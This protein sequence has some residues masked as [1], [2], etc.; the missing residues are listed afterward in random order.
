MKVNK[1]TFFAAVFLL[2]MTCPGQIKIA[3]CVIYLPPGNPRSVTRAAQELQKHIELATGNKLEIISEART[4]MIALG[5]S[6]EARKA[7]VDA[8]TMKYETHIMRTTGGNLYIAGRDI[9]GD[10]RAE[11][12]GYSYGTL[13]GVYAFMNQVM[14]I[15]F[16]M[17]TDKGTYVPKLG[18]DWKIPAVDKTY[19][20]QFEYRGFPYVPRD[21]GA[22]LEWKIRN[23]SDGRGDAGSAIPNH[24]HSWSNIYPSPGS[25]YSQAN[26]DRTAAFKEHPEFFYADNSGNRIYP[27]F[28]FALCISNPE[29]W[30]DAAER[31][32][33]LRAWYRKFYK[34]DFKFEMISLSPND[35]TNCRCEECKKRYVTITEK[36]VGAWKSKP[37]SMFCNTDLMLDY[38]RGVT[39][40]LAAKFQYLETGGLIYDHY[41][42][43]WKINR[44]K[45]PPQFGAMMAPLHLSY[46]PGRLYSKINDSW[47]KWLNDWDGMFERKYYYGLDFW[48]VQSAGAPWPVFAKMRNDTYPVLAKKGF[49][50][51]YLYGMDMLGVTAAHN[52]LQMQQAW[53]PMLDAEKA[54]DDF[55]TKAYGGGGKYVKE[56]YLL[57]EKNLTEFMTALKGKMGYYMTPELM[58]DVYAKDWKQF[59]SLM[60]KAVNAPKDENQAWRLDHFVRNMRL[61]NYHLEKMGMIPEDK[62]AKLYLSDA[63]YLSWTPLRTQG[64]DWQTLGGKWAFFLPQPKRNGF[65]QSAQVPI[66]EVRAATFKAPTGDAWFY[67]TADFLV[68]AVSDRVTFRIE[69]KAS[70]NPVTQ[71]PYLDGIPYFSVFTP[72]GE[73]YYSGIAARNKV[74]FPAKKGI[75]YFMW[76]YPQSDTTYGHTWR[77]VKANSPYAVGTRIHPAGLQ[78][79]TPAGS[80]LYFFVPAGLKKFDLIALAWGGFD[81]LDPTGKVIVSN[82]RIGGYKVIPVRRADGYLEQGVYELRVTSNL[83]GRIRFSSELPGFFVIDP[84]HALQ[85]TLDEKKL[86]ERQKKN[87]F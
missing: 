70:I 87:R 59:S 58:K 7:G 4:P 61:F 28:N 74:S 44:K 10:R 31:Y 49:N 86:L 85:V 25:L 53:N 8:S 5:S 60:E 6:P 55:C 33:K 27:K 79:H 38:Y 68:Q 35:G 23:F 20:P 9:P 36:E 48:F 50:G 83:W 29:V 66:K 40:Q 45:M 75:T 57:A 3:D 51:T 69:Q 71:K 24:G 21:R 77:I 56:I 32:I 84:A 19:T 82:K 22:C 30:K 34:L 73:L 17:P 78:I 47:H 18:K 80:R 14:G 37:Q 1:T 11:K 16:L 13:Y 39:E 46:G 64:K 62:T 41:M 2:G 43:A 52:Y 26:Q 76:I 54:F 81:I 42:Y 72:D 15:A 12:G 63:E 65:A 67:L